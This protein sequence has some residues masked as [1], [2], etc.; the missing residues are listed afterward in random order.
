[1]TWKLSS[2]EEATLREEINSFLNY[3]TVEKG[4]SENTTAA[5]Q[6][7]LQQLASFAE[8]E[9]TKQGLMPRRGTTLLP[10]WPAR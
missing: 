10:P 6:N 2:S 3:L 8:E 4:F 9:A 5:Y 7:D 1:L